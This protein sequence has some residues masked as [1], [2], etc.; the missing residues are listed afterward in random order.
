LILN[1]FLIKIRIN[2]ITMN[3]ETTSEPKTAD[4][5][6]S[7]ILAVQLLLTAALGYTFYLYQGVLAAQSASYGGCMVMF[8]VWMTHRRLQYAAELAKVAP[9]KEVKI[10]YLAA[11]QRFVFTV[12]FFILGMGWLGLPPIPLI[13]T[14]AIAHLGY[15]F[16]GQLDKL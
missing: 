1:T 16:N 8:N 9:G 3:D 15:L 14:F 11:I 7:K 13:V 6:A 12:G 5:S 4:T 10:F 2:S